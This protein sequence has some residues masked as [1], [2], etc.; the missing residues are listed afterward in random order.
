MLKLWEAKNFKIAFTLH[1]SYLY[2]A[3]SSCFNDE[4]N[5]F[6]NYSQSVVNDLSV[7]MS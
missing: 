3:L 2:L 4:E 7:I 1:V 6:S 5:Y